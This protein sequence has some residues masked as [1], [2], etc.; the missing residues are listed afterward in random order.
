[1]MNLEKG[2]VKFIEKK[3]G[4]LPENVE[5]VEENEKEIF[6]TLDF[7]DDEII[8]VWINR[9]KGENGNYRVVREA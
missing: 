9:R 1:M 6:L 2:L 4:M 8:K 3:Y 7:G 5:V